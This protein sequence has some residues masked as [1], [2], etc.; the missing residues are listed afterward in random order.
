MKKER[1][2][3]KKKEGRKIIDK[4][5]HNNYNSVPL[6]LECWTNALIRI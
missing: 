3:V 6:R 4:D 5:H 1:K 2:K